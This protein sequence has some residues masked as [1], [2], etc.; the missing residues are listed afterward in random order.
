MVT[1]LL[2]V[3]DHVAFRHSVRDL[4]NKETDLNVV[5]EASNG[6]SAIRLAHELKPHVVLMDVVMPGVGGIE[7][8][9]Q[10]R[11]ANP[12]VRVI[13][14]S[15]HAEDGFVDAMLGA[16]ASGYVLKDHA[17]SELVE[18]IQTA[19]AGGNYRGSGLS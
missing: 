17:T 8:T 2:L 9:R 3:D 15:M 4:V 14:L 18:A 10:I 7:A 19:V 1:E 12:A 5:G 11:A 16:G 13:A 6:E